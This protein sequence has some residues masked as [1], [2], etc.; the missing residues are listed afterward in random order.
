MPEHQPSPS[1]LSSTRES[2]HRVAEHVL[3]AALKRATGHIALRPG[4]GGVRTPALPDGRVLAL[5]GTHIAVEQDGAVLREAPVTTV[6]QAAEVAGVEPGFPWTTHPPGTPFAPDEPL[7]LD[8]AAAAL[9]AQWFE[10]GNRALSQFAAGTAGTA[11]TAGT[12]GT[13]TEAVDAAVP[14][15]FPEHFDL[16]VSLDRVNYGASPGDAT[17]AEPYLY[18]GPFDG[19]P[20]RDAFWNAPFGAY[21]PRTEATTSQEALAFFR[22]GRDRLAGLVRP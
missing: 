7:L 1:P 16:A 3:S 18:V 4:R 12:A 21:L 20:A 5:V 15:I 14:Q 9:L 6:R 11:K 8:P 10:L 22:D 17:I 19:P 13:A 2:L